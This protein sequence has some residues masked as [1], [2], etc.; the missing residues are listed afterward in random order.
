VHRSKSPS[1]AETPLPVSEQSAEP[2]PELSEAQLAGAAT[3]DGGPSGAACNMARWLQ[4]ALRKDSLVVAAVSRS[5]GKAILVW[6]GDWVKSA[7]ED[8]KGLAA[9]RE[10]MLWEI[11][12]APKACRD[13][14]EHGLVL[15]SLNAGHGEVRLAVG[16]EHWRWSDLLMSRAG[17]SA[18]AGA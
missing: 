10:A 5:A 16:A 4:A 8:G 7:G 15:L 18:D 11:A 17:G 14:A 3:A 13:G 2:G 12:F 1:S 6:D 9:V